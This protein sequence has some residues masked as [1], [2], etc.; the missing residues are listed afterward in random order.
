MSSTG[1]VSSDGPATTDARVVSEWKRRN[2]EQMEKIKKCCVNNLELQ[3]LVL[4]TIEGYTN[5]KALAT[6]QFIDMSTMVTPKKKGK[7]QHGRNPDYH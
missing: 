4:G 1:S 7:D 2:R 6:D 5:T 3:A